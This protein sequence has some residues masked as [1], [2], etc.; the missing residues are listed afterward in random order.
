MMLEIGK[1][2]KHNIFIDEF[3]D[4]GELPLQAV[5]GWWQPDSVSSKG[6]KEDFEI[7]IVAETLD[8]NVE[9]YEVKRNLQKYSTACLDEKVAEMQRHIFRGKEVARR[10]LPMDYVG[11]ALDSKNHRIVS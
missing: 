4:D 2:R 1:R 7:D 11:C 10:C 5:L 6:N 9:V 3:L 8:G